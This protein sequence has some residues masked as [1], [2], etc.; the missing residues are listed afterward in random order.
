MGILFIVIYFAFIFLVLEIAATLMILTGLK[1][2]IARFQVVS[3]LT[4]TGFT[5]KESELILRHP[6]RRKIAM[7]L[8]LF[9]VFSLAVLISSISG[10]L[11]ENFQIPQLT[12]I[13]LGLVVI[14]IAIKTKQINRTLTRVLHRHLQNEFAT[15]ELPLGEVLYTDEGDL[16][17]EIQVFAESKIVDKR[18]NEIFGHGADVV[19]LLIQRANRKIRRKCLDLF[20]QEGDILLVYGDHAEIESMFHYELKKM[21]KDKEDEQIVVDLT[22]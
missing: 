21:K 13:T 7:F 17:T 2:E 10:L 3:L 9:G 18:S 15:H 6:L 5:T 1:K 8:I 20:I 11:K 16:V 14:V 4:S 12:L 19:L 22:V